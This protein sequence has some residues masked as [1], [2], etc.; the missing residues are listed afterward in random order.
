MKNLCRLSR[1]LFF[2]V[3][4]LRGI[5]VMNIIAALI[6]LVTHLFTC[7]FVLQYFCLHG[8]VFLSNI[9]RTNHILHHKIIILKFNSK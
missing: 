1:G 2:L 5:K 9:T 8:F 7:A 6:F 4:I 3:K